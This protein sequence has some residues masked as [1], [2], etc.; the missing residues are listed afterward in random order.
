MYSVFI[1]DDANTYVKRQLLLQCACIEHCSNINIMDYGNLDLK[2]KDFDGARYWFEITTNNSKIQKQIEKFNQDFYMNNNDMEEFLKCFTM[3]DESALSVYIARGYSF[4]LG[5][6][7]KTTFGEP[8]YQ[9]H[10]FKDKNEKKHKKIFDIAL[11]KSQVKLFYETLT[12]WH[13]IQY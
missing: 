13:S 11:S 10:I 9:L 8:L 12:T 6:S 2:D 7:T 1:A 3:C 4:I 5:K